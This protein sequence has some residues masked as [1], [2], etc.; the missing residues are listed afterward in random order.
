METL[1]TFL[2]QHSSILAILFVFS[3][4]VVALLFH[5]RKPSKL[6]PGTLAW[7]RHLRP[8]KAI[9]F[10]SILSNV[11]CDRDFN[12]F[13]LQQEDRLVEASY[14]SNIPGVLGDLTLLVVRNSSF[15]AHIEENAVQVMLSWATKKTVYKGFKILAGWKILP[16]FSG[17]HLDPSRYSNPEEFNWQGLGGVGKMKFIMIL[18]VEEK[19]FSGNMEENHE[20]R[21]KPEIHENREERAPENLEDR[22]KD[23]FTCMSSSYSVNN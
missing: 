5:H 3:Y 18:I 17:V 14:P 6:P 21:E 7:F 10:S 22:E 12:S 19:V 1:I 4:P 15:L 13:I 2:Q 20:H 11:S 8:L 9:I 23:Y 16:V